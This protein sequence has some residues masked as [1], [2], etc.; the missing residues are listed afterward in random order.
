ADTIVAVELDSYPNTDIGDPNYP[1]I[2]IADE[3]S[4]HFSFHK[5][6]QNPKDLIL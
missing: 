4:L 2:S 1:H 6:S 3:N 5:F